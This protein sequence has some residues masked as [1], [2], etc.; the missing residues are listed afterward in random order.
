MNDA[1]LHE[2]V[3]TYEEWKKLHAKVSYASLYVYAN[4]W[5]SRTFSN[6]EGFFLAKLDDRHSLP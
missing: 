6:P 5:S 2:I 1:L 4:H 3:G